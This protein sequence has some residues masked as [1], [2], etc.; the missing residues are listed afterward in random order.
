MPSARFRV[1]ETLRG[2]LG[3]KDRHSPANGPIIEDGFTVRG[4]PKRIVETEL[5]RYQ[6]VI[7]ASTV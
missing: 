6:H 2:Q 5:A 3:S 1:S 7:G 4:G